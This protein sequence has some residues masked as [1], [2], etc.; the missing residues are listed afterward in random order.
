M[1]ATLD[2]AKAAYLDNADY[3]SDGSVAK[4]KL[5]RTACRQLIVLLPSSAS[6]GAGG[7]SQSF[8]YRVE[9]IQ[10]AFQEV[11]AWLSINDTS[12]NPSVIHPDFSCARGY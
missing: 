4:A 9:D 11:N 8:N 10:A 2:T 5:F 1:T 7:N 6:R 3:D 12:S